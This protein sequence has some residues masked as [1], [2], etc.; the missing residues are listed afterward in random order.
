MGTDVSGVKKIV[1]DRC[2]HSCLP[3]LSWVFLS[4]S[5]PLNENRQKSGQGRTR[6]AALSLCHSLFIRTK[7][8]APARKMWSMQR[9]ARCWQTHTRELPT[10]SRH[11]GTRTSYACCTRGMKIW[12]ALYFTFTLATGIISCLN[13]HPR[14]NSLYLKI[15]EEW[16]MPNIIKL[17]NQDKSRL[18][19]DLL[20]RRLLFFRR[21]LDLLAEALLSYE[22]LGNAFFSIPYLID[23]LTSLADVII[24]QMNLDSEDIKAI[25]DHKKPPASRQVQLLFKILAY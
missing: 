14:R 5:W 2:E 13:I 11:T 24:Y 10:L 8:R 17:Q 16:A 12:Q 9:S 22:T 21:E 4:W 23:W 6:Q 25:I 3:N 19:Y 18:F 20:N 7:R 15:L 1:V